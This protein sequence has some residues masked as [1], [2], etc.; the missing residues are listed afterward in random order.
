MTGDPNPAPG[1]GARPAPQ[2][3]QAGPREERLGIVSFTNVAPLHHGLEPWDEDGH[4]ARFVRGVPSELNRLLLEGEIDLTLISSI[5]FLRH[6]DRLRALP[7][8]SIATL[9]PAYSV[10]LFHWRPWAELQGARIAVSTDSA[11]SVRLLEVLL[12]RDGMRAEMVPTPPD[13][14]HMMRSYDAALL[15][16]DAA[17]REGVAR[18]RI[19]GRAPGMTDLGEAWYAR[20]RLPFTFAVWASPADRPPSAR[21]VAKLRAAREHGLGHL[22]EVAAAAADRIGV[23]PSVMLRYLANFRYHLLPPDRDGLAA[24]GQWAIPGFRPERLRYFAR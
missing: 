2:G 22:E 10:T 12:E 11:T 19:G 15:I 7:D 3:A 17:L 21:M 18:R 1:D 23:S 5:E 4:R 9:G 6:A 14:P 8:F 16:G 20:T 24:F 13:L